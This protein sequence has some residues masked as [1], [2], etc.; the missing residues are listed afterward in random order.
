MKNTSESIYKFVAHADNMRRELVKMRGELQDFIK[1][2]DYVL[3]K[4][5]LTELDAI[6]MYDMDDTMN[7]LKWLVT[8]LASAMCL[9]E[10]GKEP[11]SEIEELPPDQC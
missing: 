6:E 3:P 11:A 5:C 7:E 9:C 10:E 1:H 4:E 8:H 2:T